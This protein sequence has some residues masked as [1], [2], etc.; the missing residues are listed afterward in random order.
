MKES[1]ENSTYDVRLYPSDWRFSAAIVGII[2]FFRFCETNLNLKIDY[3]EDKDSILYHSEDVL[4]EEARSRYLQ[5]VENEFQFGMPHRVIEDMLKSETPLTSDQ[6][7]LI[8]DKL[9]ANKVCKEVFENIKY[10]EENRQTILD[11][12][13]K[14]REDLILKTYT[15][16]QSM[17]AKY[18]HSYKE[19]NFLFKN[20]CKTC[21]VNNYYED[22][23]KKSK[24]ISFF[25][26]SQTL[27]IQDFQ[28]FDFIPFAFTKTEDSFFINNN[29]SI[30][31]LYNANSD[32]Q[33]K[34]RVVAETD[35]NSFQ[36]SFYDTIKEIVAY[37]NY[38]VEVIHIYQHEN[39]DAMFYETIFLR[40]RAVRILQNITPVDEKI[41]KAPCKISKDK[42]YCKISDIVIKH[43]INQQ[44]LDNLIEKLIKDNENQH[45]WL[46]IVLIKINQQIYGG[47]KMED[48][49]LNKAVYTGKDVVR[50][51]LHENAKNKINSYR[52]KL[53][54]ALAMH[55]Y[56]RFS[57]VLLQL[58][59]YV[60]IPFDFAYDLFE[61]F[62]LNKNIA[63]AFVASLD[64][65]SLE[66][67]QDEEK[68]N[69]K[70]TEVQE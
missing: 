5:F 69:D 8:N 1:I 70:N 13:E 39:T 34:L 11:L 32:L 63:Y 10:T 60:G 2:K 14:Y 27:I 25:G 20:D 41:L 66:K 31:D 12:I 64:A 62:E 56:D 59:S 16:A 29:C 21:R 17:Y 50:K 40:K 33:W 44:H 58:S 15:K 48:K 26:N 46:L 52:Q 23:D 37:V 45:Y 19:K 67:K 38:D 36:Y 53:I 61:N 55:D 42:N 51:L 28:E 49:R 22:F 9:K 54:S 65:N 3:R 57:E 4:G 68:N 30:S 43:I 7:K 24:S 47:S 18:C 6:I 35:K